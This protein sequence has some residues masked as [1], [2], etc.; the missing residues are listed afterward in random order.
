[1]AQTSR[2]GAGNGTLLKLKENYVGRR[3][4]VSARGEVD[5]S[6]AADLRAGI[7]SAATRAFEIWLDLTETS[8][9]DS[10]ALHALTE[11]RTR[12]VEANLRLVLICPE[13]PVLRLLTLTGFDQ[14]FEI[15]A[16][17]SAANGAA[18]A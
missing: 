8:F 6:N 3:A 12:L 1:M 11:A 16:D 2:A 9:M 4:V 18:L 13:G 5:M 10:T 17:R 15:Y 14:I 7:E